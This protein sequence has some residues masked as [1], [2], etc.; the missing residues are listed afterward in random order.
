MRTLRTLAASELRQ[1]SRSRWVVVG[2]LTLA[3]ASGAVSVLAGGTEAD[4]GTASLDATTS[5]LLQIAVLFPPLLALVLG[6][7]ALAGPRDERFLGMLAAQ[8]IRRRTLVGAAYLGL[9]GAL[10]LALAFGFGFSALVLVADGGGM[11]TASLA[12]LAAASG[13]ATAAALATG[14]AV[15]AWASSRAQAIGTAVGAWFLLALGYDLVLAAA[16]PSID[17]SFG[18]SFL[19]IVA[20]PLEAGRLLGLLLIEGGDATLGSLGT[21]LV[22]TRGVLTAVATCAVTLAMWILGGVFVATSGLRRR[23]L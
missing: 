16:I 3:T 2:A 17:A 4:L 19:A 11:A 15:S 22:D 6:A 10:G 21:Y 20:N 18:V 5:A 9:A 13:G 12:A 14:L 8:P 1:A 23:D 7:G